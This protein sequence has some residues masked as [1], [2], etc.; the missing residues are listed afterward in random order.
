MQGQP[1]GLSGCFCFVDL[2]FR[3]RPFRVHQQRDIRNLGSISRIKLHP[4]CRERRPNEGCAGDIP[5]GPIE[6]CNEAIG[7]GIA[8]ISE[9]DRDG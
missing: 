9:D 2:D 4:L 5:S 1:R 3:E 6:A 7:D 8:A